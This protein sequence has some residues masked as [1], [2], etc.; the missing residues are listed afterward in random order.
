MQMTSMTVFF[1]AMLLLPAF[2]GAGA[3]AV[4]TDDNPFNAEAPAELRQF[5]FWLGE[6]DYTGRMI[7]QD[8]SWKEGSGTNTIT[9]T[10][11][12][13]ALE[14]N[15]HS[16]TPNSWRGMSITV[17]NSQAGKFQQQWVDVQGQHFLPFEGGMEGETMVLYS[18][19]R[20]IQGAK[21]INK[22]VFKDIKA[23]SFTWSYEMTLD[24]GKTWQPRWVINYTR[25]K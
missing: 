4:M 12:G 6:W 17:Y 1:G 24:E 10:L 14:E 5:A 25:K 18:P 2:S 8:G 16:I 11:D 23:D 3:V 13:Y 9:V 7:Q 22:M 19:E 15:F 20:E 21:V